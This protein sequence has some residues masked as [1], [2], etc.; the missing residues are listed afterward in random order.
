MLTASHVTLRFGARVLISDA[1]FRVNPGDKIGLVGRNGAGKTTLTALLA[2]ADQPAEGTVTRSGTIGYLPQDPRDGD[3]SV[4]ARDRIL[5][6]RGLDTALAAMHAAE[7]RMA[8]PA[9]SEAAMRDYT[10]AEAEFTAGGGY[11]AA[12]EAAG[13]AASLGLPHRVM[14][15]AL[16][17]LSGGQLCRTALSRI[18]LSQAD[19]LLLVDRTTHPS[20]D[21]VARLRGLLRSYAGSVVGISNDVALL[22]ATVNTVLHLDASRWAID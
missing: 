11:A 14:T 19:T 2:G 7:T 12:S 17:T 9:T 20:A 10:R 16:S 6:A 22:G 1:S 5:S 15:Q 21:S 4:T 3:L 8:D 18:L 13:V